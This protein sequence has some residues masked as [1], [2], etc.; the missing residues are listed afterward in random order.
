MISDDESIDF[1]VQWAKSCEAMVFFLLIS[2]S[3]WLQE[4]GWRENCGHC[5]F[6]LAENCITIV[7]YCARTWTFQ[8]KAACY[9]CV[10]PI[11]QLHHNLKNES[12]D[13]GL[14][15]RSFT[16][17]KCGSFIENG[18]SL[19]VSIKP[20]WLLRFFALKLPRTFSFFLFL[21][22]KLIGPSLF[23]AKLR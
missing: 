14:R 21:N 17:G 15:Y 18:I 20:N 10:K 12:C 23:K 13:L 16:R 6:L 7:A 19:R 3:D 5:F 22:S 11:S 8:F 2:R 9:F 1:D 4:D